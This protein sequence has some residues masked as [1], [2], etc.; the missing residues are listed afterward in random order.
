[1]SFSESIFATALSAAKIAAAEIPDAVTA[2]R[3][4]DDL[5]LL[6]A[7]RDLSEL[8]RVVDARSSL[9]AGEIA[10]RSRR[11]LGYTGLAQKEGFQTAEKLIQ[12]TTGSTRRE[13]TTLVTAGVLVHDAMALEAA[14][15]VTG[16]VPEGFTVREPW[17]GG[18]GSAVA[19][20]VLTVEAA[21]A[22][23]NGLGEPSPAGTDGVTVEQLADAVR[24]LVKEAIGDGASEGGA[25]GDGT[26]GSSGLNADLLY[27]RARQLRDELD[28]AG[29]AARERVIYEQRSFRRV[30]RPNGCSR[31]I[32]DGD[33]ETSAWLDD[34]YDKLTSPRRGGPR[35]ID[36]TDRAWAEQIATDPRTT[37]QYL[38]D[39]MIGLLRKGVDTDLAGDARESGDGRGR[40]TG[41]AGSDTA[42]ADTT[43]A[44]MRNARPRAPRI[45]G[46]RAPAVRV[47]VTEESLRNRTGHGRIEGIDT[48]VSIETVER[49]ICTSGTVPI[50]LGKGGNV[51]DL[52]REQRL[53]SARQKAALAARDGGCLWT[54]CDRPASWT[55]A[56]HINHWARDHGHTDL[57]DGVLLCRHHHLLLHNNHWEIIRKGNTYWLVPPPDIDPAQRPRPLRSKS[58]ALRDLHREPQPA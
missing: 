8:R 53:F 22:I 39:A 54:D 32:L 56:H 44:T 41:T 58:A 36:P 1:M 48:P 2:V 11:E 24:V 27:R 9:V 49:I 30:R 35:F 3:A 42:G 31:F 55:E 29:I 52:G 4:L 14:D 12:H 25:T 21:T 26:T 10:F 37:D 57:A 43:D 47:L 33:L 38:H 18:V 19:A 40:S 17:L 51:L 23:R 15:P 6:A 13:A 5:G 34:V 45:V 50:V 20:G 7:Q 46:S 28:E 16:E